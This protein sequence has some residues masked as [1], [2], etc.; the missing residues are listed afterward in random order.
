MK[1]KSN[2]W[3]KV[4]YTVV[5]LQPASHFVCEQ[6][7]VYL[8]GISGFSKVSVDSREEIVPRQPVDSYFP[9]DFQ[10]KISNIRPL[11]WSAISPATSVK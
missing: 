7:I 8:W 6:S 2:L 11:I 9:Y 4:K 5:F 3:P 1:L 10:N